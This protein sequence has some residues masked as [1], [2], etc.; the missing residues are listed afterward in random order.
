MKELS[1]P[2]IVRVIARLN[3]GGPARQAI[4]LHDRLRG[5]GFETVLVHGSVGPAEASLEDLL[6]SRGLV[7]QKVR[8][9]GATIRPLSDVRAFASLL[10]LVFREHP[11]VVHTHTAKAGTLGRLVAS[12]YNLTRTSKNRCLIVHT[13]HGHVLEGYFGPWATRAV[14]VSER[15]L[16]RLTDRIITISERQREELVGRFLVAAPD[17]VS[18]VPLGLELDPFLSIGG[19]DPQ[20]RRSIGFP[21]D[22]LL[23]GCIGRLVRIKDVPTLLRA[24]V[25]A[26]ERAPAVR[27]AIVGDGD[28]R[29]A[30]EELAVSLGL[31]DTVRFLG[32]RRDLLTVYTGLDVV[33]LSSRNEGTPVAL[34]EAMAAG[35]PTIATEVGGV[36]DVVKH[37]ETGLLVPAGDPARL[38][39]A[40][41]RMA[42]SAEYRRRL[43]EAGR[44][45]AATYQSEHLIRR[46]T[47]L[48]RDGVRAK[49]GGPLVDTTSL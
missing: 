11:D 41:V 49:R 30:L 31:Q 38:A 15:L 46:L 3:V 22:A 47:A 10:R 2:K 12:L 17:R 25:L 26:R 14:R 27:L 39:D 34:I 4:L 44:R 1:R 32:W 23:F 37:G 18:I 7:S 19:P 43:G 42:E 13:F 20:F 33:A 45:A 28:Q 35:R 36:P 48:Y 16:G 21:E 8:D 24:M 40:M 29:H 9:L 5:E 6:Q